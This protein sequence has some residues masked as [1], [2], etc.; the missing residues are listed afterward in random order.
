[1]EEGPAK[2]GATFTALMCVCHAVLQ[3][4]LCVIP[5]TGSMNHFSHSTGPNV[6]GSVF[7]EGG[8]ENL[9]TRLVV[10][11]DPEALQLLSPGFL[12]YVDNRMRFC[13]Q[14]GLM[15]V[16]GHLSGNLHNQLL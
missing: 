1:M 6:C 7:G 3:M 16:T 15:S 8:G 10:S 5:R 11:V 4:L 2:P 12:K 14:D 9:R 13:K